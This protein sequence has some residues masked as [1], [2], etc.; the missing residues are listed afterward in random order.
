MVCLFIY[1]QFSDTS[2]Y[3]GLIQECETWLFGNDY[4][5][6]AD[7]AK[8]LATFTR[9]LNNGLDEVTASIMEVDGRWQYDDS[10]YTDF[11]IATTTLVDAQQDYQLSVSHIKILGVE[12]KK[13]DGDYYTLSPLDLQDIRRKGLSI[14]EFMDEKGLPIYYDKQGDSLVLY[15]APDATQV[16][17]AA[18][19]KVFF[20]REP[21]YFEAGD[22]TK[23][24][25]IP[26][27]FHDIPALFACAK[28]AKSNL[29][30][31]KARELDA[32]IEKRMTKLRDF[33][34]NRSVDSKPVIRAKFK[35]AA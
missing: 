19:L 7:N 27:L 11:P 31:E 23:K 34:S 32:E 22:T 20:Q 13:A 6:I 9:L 4:G 25:G 2:T 17:T 8:L 1:M 3:N 16:T 24:P 35:S 30:G 29:M 14:T 15:P 33:F 28:Y 5:A 26:S 21:D 12:I 18:G 10:N